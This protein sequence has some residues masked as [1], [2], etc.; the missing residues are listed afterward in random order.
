MRLSSYLRAY[1]RYLSLKKIRSSSAGKSGFTK[2]LEDNMDTVMVCKSSNVANIHY[3]R[4]AFVFV[5]QIYAVL[6]MSV[7]IQR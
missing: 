5:A 3:N 6:E 4:G 7:F 2:K 1:C